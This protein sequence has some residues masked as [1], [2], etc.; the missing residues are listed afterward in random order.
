MS[1]NTGV[2]APNLKEPNN[3]YTLSFKVSFK[4]DQDTVYVAMCYPYTY[5]DCQ[6]FLDRI[7]DPIESQNIL[8]RTVLSKTIAGNNMQMLI[9]TNFMAS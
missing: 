8:R 9:I 7:C 1:I 5:T 2:T 3:L 4:H 6:N